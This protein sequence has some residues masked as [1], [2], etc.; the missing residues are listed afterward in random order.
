MRGKKG[1]K[2][3][4]FFLFFLGGVGVSVMTPYAYP[5]CSYNIVLCGSTDSRTADPVT[6]GWPW[7]VATENQWPGSPADAAGCAARKG[8]HATVLCLTVFCVF[9]T[10]WSL[11]KNCLDNLSI[12]RYFFFDL[13][14]FKMNKEAFY[15]FLF[16]M[17]VWSRSSWFYSCSK[18]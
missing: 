8:T 7:Q 12:V 14:I 13:T 4:S 9:E 3:S 10:W 17:P 18:N 11:V 5:H 15:L 2:K 16:S 6:E 1:K